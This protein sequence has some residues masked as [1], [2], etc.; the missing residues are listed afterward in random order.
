[1]WG[2]GGSRM[3]GCAFQHEENE[4]LYGSA[5]NGQSRHIYPG[6]QK[7]VAQTDDSLN[8]YD[9]P[10]HENDAGYFA[11]GETAD[12]T[13][14]NAG[15]NEGLDFADEYHS[16]H[17]PYSRRT[18][19]RPLSN[20][21]SDRPPPPAFYRHRMP[22]IY[23]YMY[24]DEDNEWMT[25]D[26]EEDVVHGHPLQYFPVEVPVVRQRRRFDST[27]A[28]LWSSPAGRGSQQMYKRR[29]ILREGLSHN[30]RKMSDDLAYETRNRVHMSPSPSNIH[31]ALVGQVDEV[32]D[33]ADTDSF[34]GHTGNFAGNRA[35]GG[36]T[37]SSPNVAHTSNAGL[38]FDHTDSIANEVP[39]Q[40]DV[41]VSASSNVNKDAEDLVRET[42]SEL[43]DASAG[44]DKP[45]S[46]NDNASTDDHIVDHA[47]QSEVVLTGPN[48]LTGETT[49][50]ISSQRSITL[51][52]SPTR[53]AF[54]SCNE[55]F[56]S[57]IVK[58]ADYSMHS[59]AGNAMEVSARSI[60]D[61]QAVSDAAEVSY[62]KV[63]PCK[64]SVVPESE[65][66]HDCSL[67]EERLTKL[68][69]SN[70][71]TDTI[72]INNHAV[73]SLER[74]NNVEADFMI[75]KTSLLAQKDKLRQ[76]EMSRKSCRRL[77][78]LCG[79]VY[80]LQCH[81]G[82]HSC[83]LDASRKHDLMGKLDSCLETI[84]IQNEQTLQEKADALQAG[85]E[86]VFAVDRPVVD[87]RAIESTVEAVKANDIIS[88][89][90]NQSPIHIDVCH[91]KLNVANDAVW[92]DDD[93]FEEAALVDLA[94]ESDEQETFAAQISS[95]KSTLK[96]DAVT[97]EEVG[98]LR[99]PREL[100]PFVWSL[101]ER[102][103]SFG[104]QTYV[105]RAT[106]K[107]LLDEIAKMDPYYYLHP[108][109]VSKD[110]DVSSPLHSS[111]LPGCDF[112][113]RGASALKWERKLVSQIS[114]R[115]KSFDNVAYSLARTSSGGKEVLN[116]K[117]MNSIIRKLHLVAMQLHSLVS[118]LYCVKGHATCKEVES[119][120]IALNNSHFERKMV[121]YKSMLKLVVPHKYQ[122]QTSQEQHSSNEPAEELLRD[123]YEFFP[124]LLLCID[125]WGY[126]YRESLVKRHNSKS[127]VGDDLAGLGA[128]S[129]AALF[130]LRYFRSVECLSFDFEYDSNG[131]LHCICD[132]LLNIVCLWNDFKWTDELEAVA[133]DRVMSF[134][135]NVTASIVKI[136]DFHAQHLQALWSVRLLDKP[137]QLRSIHFTEFN[138]YYSDRSEGSLST[139]VCSQSRTP[140]V[141]ESRGIG[142]NY[143][144]RCGGHD[145]AAEM[146]EQ[147]LAE[148]YWNRKVTS[149][150]ILNQGD[151]AME[152]DI[153]SKPQLLSIE[154]ICSW[155]QQTLVS[156]LL[157]WSDVYVIRAEVNALSAVTNHMMK[158]EV[159]KFRFEDNDDN[160]TTV[161]SSTRQLLA[162]VNRAQ[163]L[164]RDALTGSEKLAL[165]SASNQLPD[166]KKH[167]TPAELEV[168]KPGRSENETITSSMEAAPSCQTSAS[169]NDANAC[170]DDATSEPMFHVE[171][172]A[173]KDADTCDVIEDVNIDTGI[174]AEQPELKDLIQL[175]A[176]TKQ[177]VQELCRHR[178]RSARMREKVQMQSLQLARQT[179]EIFRNIRNMYASERR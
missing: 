65:A 166:E 158:Q 140:G 44:D 168:G 13:D 136:L 76:V 2:E 156:Y 172:I 147:R 45:Q 79:V 150:S 54:E 96:F 88:T 127:L 144:S 119:L 157:R 100:P 97:M 66:L 68:V 10:R 167:V 38:D 141:S 153:A 17:R 110:V 165:H 21:R 148:E 53:E 46:P 61:T 122:Q 98:S 129:E 15:P 117:K 162:A 74:L 83:G 8:D 7:R 71:A 149:L 64:V 35:E 34:S 90:N 109:N 62:E 155:D 69:V 43:Q 33:N 145:V 114:S 28:E 102:V 36:L 93:W 134:E 142:C 99:W 116:R 48:G 154:A 85:L 59:T 32:V 50:Q 84:S 106:L 176:V 52:N 121:V 29:R 5:C 63:I 9:E 56:L 179:A 120:P 77:Q 18:Y 82:S 95:E 19:K 24:D 49:A 23:D 124:E 177:D 103:I 37:P 104:P 39:L 70:V 42:L 139:T 47:S 80:D 86:H 160:K 126:N 75:A 146:V 27:N 92:E 67:N 171:A 125:I 133:L 78:I 58:D 4:A 169:V 72:R 175:L 111:P 178:P 135:S 161:D 107:R 91:D 131:L 105:M 14:E 55:S 112:G 137:E 159:Q 81:I 174:T 118:H 31:T 173:S 73:A 89:S 130:P 20:M 16:V 132:E 12:L 170:S 138:A 163:I 87:D 57:S 108:T 164:I 40:L 143:E 152:V 3:Y 41:E 128:I 151:D 51:T 94:S 115:M 113:C 11:Y 22:Y 1:M 60:E 26:E 101:L 25:E 30:S 123:T 6:A